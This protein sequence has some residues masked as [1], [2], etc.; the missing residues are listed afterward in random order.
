MLVRTQD[1]VTPLHVAVKRPSD[2][3]WATLDLL[4][5]DVADSVRALLRAKASPDAQDKATHACTRALCARILVFFFSFFFSFFF[6]VRACAFRCCAARLRHNRT[7]DVF[8]FVFSRAL[9]RLAPSF[10]ACF[11]CAS[12]SRARGVLC[13]YVCVWGV[14]HLF[15]HCRF[16]VGRHA[17][18]ACVHWAAAP[19]GGAPIRSLL[20]P[21]FGSGREG[22]RGKASCWGSGNGQ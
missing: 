20:G 22:S 17:A 6:F 10:F 7:K 16:L 21:P 15:S 14:C 18:D 12:L 8:F 2:P 11:S 13:V 4:E 1:G 19:S 9:F 5:Q 3:S